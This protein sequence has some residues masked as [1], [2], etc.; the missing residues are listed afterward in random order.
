[1]LTYN[2]ERSSGDTLAN[3]LYIHIRSDIEK[4]QIKPD[5][6]LPSKRSLAQHLGISV[7]TVEASYS[8]LMAEG[9]IRSRQ[10]SGYYVSKLDLPYN[11]GTSRFSASRNDRISSV[12]NTIGF[13]ND[14]SDLANRCIAPNL[15]KVQVKSEGNNCRSKTVEAMRTSYPVIADFTGSSPA[16]QLFPYSQ[17]AKTMRKAL[18]ENT[19]ES[20]ILASHNQGS[21]SL[22]AAIAGY[23]KGFR[24]MNVSPEQ[25]IIGAGAQN[26]YQLIIQLL[27]RNSLYALENPGYKRLAL[28]YKANQV[29]VKPCWVDESGFNPEHLKASDIKVVHCMPSHQYP[30]GIVMP[31]SRRYEI[32]NWASH[33]SDRFII[34]DDYDCE[35]RLKGKPI[36]SL[37]SIDDT[38]SV[39]YLNTFT[40]SLGLAFRIGYAVLPWRLVEKYQT[41]FSFYSNTV[42]ALDQ[43]TLTKFIDS[44]SYERH[45]NRTRTYYRRT[46]EAFLDALMGSGEHL[47]RLHGVQN[48]LHFLLETPRSFP[49]D[50]FINNAKGRGVKLSRLSDFV[51][52]CK[53]TSKPCVSSS[54][55]QRYFV[56]DFTSLTLE[57]AAKAAEALIASIP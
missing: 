20:L 26:L 32:L 33:E 42:G 53:D 51:L 6:K 13:S 37:Q 46:L 14:C 50:E 40:K 36:P 56:M 24:A 35:F 54:E 17:W 39:I 9:F 34:E 44:G 57:N 22:R 31:V 10:R 21:L 12:N 4:G 8:Q 29:K 47:F 55:L 52:R 30:T 7:I 48:G 19:E 3:Q 18:L 16:T 41:K 15:C 45:V 43:L 27:G 38:G 28:I 23:L 5:E 1:M 49:I 2:L 11:L 25:I